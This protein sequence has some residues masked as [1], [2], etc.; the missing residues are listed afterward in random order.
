MDLFTV[1]KNIYE[2]KKTDWFKELE[3]SNISGYIVFKYLSMNKNL[4]NEIGLLNNY[5]FVLN[6]KQFIKL[7]WLVVPKQK[8]PYVKYIKENI[9]VD[10]EFYDVLQRRLK[11]SDNDFNNCKQ[12]LKNIIFNEPEKYFAELGLKKSFYDK[13]N[14][15]F[16]PNEIGTREIKRG[17]EV[18]F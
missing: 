7:C 10:K 8:T 17:L 3:H 18:F 6:D 15:A 12:R 1:L 9:D 11:M 5:V 4:Y 2:N 14:I 16:K 13:Y